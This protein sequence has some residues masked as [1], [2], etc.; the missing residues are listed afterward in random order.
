MAL[1]YY[2]TEQVA[3]LFGISVSSVRRK[4]NSG[5]IRWINVGSV[6]RPRIRI[7]EDDLHAYTEA[8]AS[9]PSKRSA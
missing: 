9:Q 4:I 6:E 2:S 1:A 5:E 3:K 7:T 8:Q